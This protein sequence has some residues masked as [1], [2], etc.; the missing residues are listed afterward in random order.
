MSYCNG[1]IRMRSQSS[2]PV[3]GCRSV[4]PGLA[5]RSSKECRAAAYRLIR[6]TLVDTE[7]VERLRDQNVD[8]YIIKYVDF[9]TFHTLITLYV[10]RWPATTSML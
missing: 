8:W 7:S 9:T 10:D 5:D 2:Q 3:H 6:H 4:M 1:A